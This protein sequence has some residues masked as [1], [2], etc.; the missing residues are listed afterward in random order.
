MKKFFQSMIALAVLVAAGIPFSARAA[1]DEE[2][3]ITLFSDAQK[4]GAGGFGITLGTD[5]QPAYFDID[6][7]F[8]KEEVE[9]QPWTVEDGSIKG[10][11]LSLIHI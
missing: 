1:E 11:Y 7:G 4:E 3:I 5:T 10:T 8:G 2:P 6:F 9:V